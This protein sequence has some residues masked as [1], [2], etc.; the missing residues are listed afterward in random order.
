MAKLRPTIGGVQVVDDGSAGGTCVFTSGTTSCFVGRSNR[1]A[2]ALGLCLSILAS[3]GCGR[4]AQ[5]SPRRR[6]SGNGRRVGAF[7]E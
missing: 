5:F 3:S 1:V 2:A 4:G 6:Q 7:Y